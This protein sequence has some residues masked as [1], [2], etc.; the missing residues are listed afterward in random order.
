MIES[1]EAKLRLLLPVE[2][3]L[4]DFT[5]VGLESAGDDIRAIVRLVRGRRS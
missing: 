1:I 5:L 2:G 4:Y 3:P